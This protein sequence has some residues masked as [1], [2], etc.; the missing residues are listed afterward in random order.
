MTM[1]CISLK[2][3]IRAQPF[4]CLNNSRIWGEDLAQSD[5]LKP[6]VALAAVCSNAV[7][8]LLFVHRSMLLP[9]F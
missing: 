1:H 7:V 5:M 4:L 2:V 8:L 6:T 3:F 9:L